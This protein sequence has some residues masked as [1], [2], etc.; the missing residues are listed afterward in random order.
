MKAIELIGD[1]DSQHRLRADVPEGLPAGQVRLI[2]LLPEEENAGSAWT[3]G[4]ANDWSAD[5]SDTRQDIY[6][7]EDGQPLNGSG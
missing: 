7:L 6:T 4:I 5:L 3:D 1:I 2:V